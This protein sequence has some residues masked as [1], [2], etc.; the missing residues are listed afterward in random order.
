MAV[1]K[2]S[3]HAPEMVPLVILVHMSAGRRAG[4]PF[5]AGLRSGLFRSARFHF[6]L[7]TVLYGVGSA[8]DPLSVLD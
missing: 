5:L 7:K 1:G 6:G 2:L 3:R 4:G 8:R